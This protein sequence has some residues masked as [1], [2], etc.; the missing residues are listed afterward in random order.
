MNS[1][2]VDL[3]MQFNEPLENDFKLDPGSAS[4]FID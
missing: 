2:M 1:E 3:V 4:S